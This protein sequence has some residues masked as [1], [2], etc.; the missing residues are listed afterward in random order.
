MRL[1]VDGKWVGEPRKVPYGCSIVREYFQTKYS[2]GIISM[3]LYASQ[4]GETGSLKPI[5]LRPS[6]EQ[7]FK[8]PILNFKINEKLKNYIKLF[9]EYSYGY[10]KIDLP[11]IFSVD[12][13]KNIVKLK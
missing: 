2:K 6:G 7:P 12:N 3:F 5:I 1:A 9:E 11:E 8:I 4:T 13:G 10:I